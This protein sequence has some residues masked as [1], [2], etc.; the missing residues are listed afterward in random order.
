M[1]D[2]RKNKAYFEGLVI[3]FEEALTETQEALDAGNFSTPSS[4]VDISLRLFQLSIMRAVTLYSYGTSLEILKPYV[5]AIL[6]FRQQLTIHADQLPTA[7]QAYRYAFEQL[8]EAAA[9]CGSENINRYIYT[10]WWL[11]LLKACDV[12]QPHI[13]D[14][15]NI[16]GERGKDKLLG[17]PPIFNGGYL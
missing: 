6:P 8:G 5:L 13:N 14:A 9:A 17:N 15:L 3:D 11:S 16:V 2:T 4:R 10:L 1:R 12:E 7:H